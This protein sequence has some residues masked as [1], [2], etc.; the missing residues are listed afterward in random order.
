MDAA[1]RLLV[2]GRFAQQYP[3]VLLVLVAKPLTQNQC[4]VGSGNQRKSAGDKAEI[5]NKPNRRILGPWHFSLST[6]RGV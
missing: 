5:L 6:R 3:P 1:G 4:T 2:A